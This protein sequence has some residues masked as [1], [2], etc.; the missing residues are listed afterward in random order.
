MSLGLVVPPKAINLVGELTTAERSFYTRLQ[1]G[2]VKAKNENRSP[3]TECDIFIVINCNLLAKGGR[4]RR[5]C[6][7]CDVPGFW[8]RNRK[9]ERK[10]K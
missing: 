6:A 5:D 2:L 9:A 10:E 3:L 7:S 4:G 8:F 1:F